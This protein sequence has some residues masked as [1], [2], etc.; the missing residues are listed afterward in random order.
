MKKRKVLL[1]EDNRAFSKL[2]SKM[3]TESGF[4]VEEVQTAKEALAKVDQVDLL[5]LDLKLPDMHGR[6]VLHEMRENRGSFLPVIISTAK[7]PANGEREDYEKYG[8]ID[9][10]EKPFPMEKLIEAVKKKCGVCESLEILDESTKILSDFNA[11]QSKSDTGFWNNVEE[12][13]G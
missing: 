6:E 10:L 11:K 3:L 1:A 13:V 7:L 2:A 8:I 9:F 5:V 12:Q 4:E